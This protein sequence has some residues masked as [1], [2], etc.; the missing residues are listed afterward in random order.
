MCGQGVIVLRD[1]EYDPPAYQFAGEDEHKVESFEATHVSVMATLLHRPA[2]SG[3]SGE[4][5]R[6]SLK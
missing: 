4:G 2:T 3:F 5:S 6:E 1:A